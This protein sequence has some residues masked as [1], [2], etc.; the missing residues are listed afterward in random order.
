MTFPDPFGEIHMTTLHATR[1]ANYWSR[2]P[3]TQMDLVVGAYEDI[4]SADVPGFTEALVRALPGLHGHRCS[5]GEPGGFIVRLRRGTYAPHITEH[6]ALELQNM[7][8]HDVGYGRTRGGDAKGEYTLVFEHVHEAVGL[9]AAALALE[10]VQRAFASTLDSI[11]HAVR[12]LEALA[13]T[14]PTPP[15]TQH[16]L[17][18][19]SGGAYRGEA[20]EALLRRYGTTEELIV[21]VSPAYLLQAGLPYARSEIAVI[22]DTDLAGIPDRYRTSDRAPRLMSIL[23]D[24]VDVGSVV[25]AP[26]KEWDLQD[27]AR[28]AGCRVAVFSTSD[29]ITHRDKKVARAAA[30]VE[31]GTIVVE[32]ADKLFDVGTLDSNTP[33]TADVAAALAAFTLEEIHPSRREP[34]AAAASR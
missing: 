27:R 18:G 20:R 21:D 2:N 34:S 11:D 9:R 32:H 31:D 8:G 23:A 16:V 26:A 24:A 14:P 28:D 5:I 30:W 13:Q 7:I 33:A 4:H 17:C 10:I 15:L 6:I 12:E 29:D 1:G 22:L 19:I 25:I 3:V